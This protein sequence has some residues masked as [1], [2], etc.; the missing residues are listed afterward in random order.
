[1]ILAIDTSAGQ[2]AVALVGQTTE[3]RVEAMDRGH[4][5]ALMPMIDEVTGG[6]YRQ[7]TRIAVCTGPGSFT[8]LRIGIAAARGLALGLEIPCIGITRFEALAYGSPQSAI[9]LPG[10][11]GAYFVQSFDSGVQIA[12]P[13]VV[14]TSPPDAL[15][16]AEGEGLPDPVIIAQLAA[17]RAPG[18]PPA[19][20]Y[21]REANAAPARDAPPVML[22]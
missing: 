12:P 11:N 5:E 14:D 20:L 1:M 18:L 3:S 10:R 4:A 8:G 7:I 9:A 15:V 16:F 19:P 17:G 21:L 6:N 13:R 22:D 2:C